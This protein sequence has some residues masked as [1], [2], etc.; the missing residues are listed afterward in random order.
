MFILWYV[1]NAEKGEFG[2]QYTRAK[3]ENNDWADEEHG[4]GF[5]TLYYDI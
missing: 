4:K 5:E 2:G 1:E 3:N